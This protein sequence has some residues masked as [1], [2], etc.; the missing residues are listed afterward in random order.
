MTIALD[1]AIY[2]RLLGEVQ[3]K[4]I[5]TEAENE[6]YL[7]EVEKLMALGENL[8]LEQEHLLRLLVTLIEEFESQHY[9]LRSATP[10]E[11]L[12]ELVSD[13]QLKQ[14]D[15]IPVFGSQGI[16]SEVLHGKRAI[17]K[18]QAKALGAFFHVS[19]ALFFD[20]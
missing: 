16:A 6:F 4:V 5:E 10:H 18:S 1:K 13:R 20:L 7:A 15:L 8:T 9:Q 12:N 11:I 17:S 14:K 2:A 19:P 3:P